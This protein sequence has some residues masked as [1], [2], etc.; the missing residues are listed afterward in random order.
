MHT[1]RAIDEYEYIVALTGLEL[2]DNKCFGVGYDENSN[3]LYAEVQPIEG[4]PSNW[5][6]TPGWVI[7]WR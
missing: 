6:S 3:Q 4:E 7:Y 5:A 1:F 2:T